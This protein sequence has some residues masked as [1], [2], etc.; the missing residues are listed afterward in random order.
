MDIVLNWL[1][2]AWI[3]LALFIV[4]KGQRIKSI[5]FVLACILTLRFQVELMHQIDY[6]NGLLPFLDIPLL[7]RGFMAY[8]AFIA[9]FLILLHMSRERDPYVYIAASIAVFTMAFC[10]SSFILVL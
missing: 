7:Y 9:V 2:V 1:D 4:H 8:G 5:L 6:P 10:V 3:P